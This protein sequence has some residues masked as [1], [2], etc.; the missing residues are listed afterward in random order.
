[1]KTEA[2]RTTVVPDSPRQHAWRIAEA[3]DEAWHGHFG[4][5]RVEIPISV[6]AAL[7][8]VEQR[9]PEGPDLADLF[10]RFD[11][12]GFAALLRNIWCK[13]AI[14]RPDLL[15]RTKPLW[16][17][18]DE[19]D[20]DDHLLRAVHATGQAALKKRQLQLTGV[21][22]RRE[23]VDLL[24]SVLQAMRSRS[25]R[26]GLGQFL[27]PVDVAETIGSILH[28]AVTGDHEGEEFAGG[29]LVASEGARVMEPCCGTGTMLLGAAK[30]MRQQGH[31]PAKN[32]WWANDID[33]LA[34]ACCA[35]NMHCWGLGPR[36]VIG[37]GDGLLNDWMREAL[38]QRQAAIDELLGLW[39]VARKMA[40]LRRLLDLPT[41]EDPLTRHIREAATKMPPEPRP[42]PPHSSTFDPDAAYRQARLF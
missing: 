7:A 41:P 4:G 33:W 3:V 42:A 37:C 18:L 25:A 32:E 31:D 14:V 24:G 12:H 30:A 10:L 34:A 26:G 39:E 27:T 40:T 6:V 22:W 35:V 21:A 20:L 11:Q 5:S 13:F 2:R 28:P 23:E 1:M 29:L 16:E 19:D 15:P 9:D 8:L 36:V 38:D 17:W